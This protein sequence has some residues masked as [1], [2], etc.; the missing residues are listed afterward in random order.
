MQPDLSYLQG[1]MLQITWSDIK[2]LFSD[3]HGE[4]TEDT[5]H[6]ITCEKLVVRI[7][8]AQFLLTGA[9]TIDGRPLA[10]ATIAI[11]K[12]G[13]AITAKAQDWDVADGLVTVKNASLTLLIGKPGSADQVT[14]RSDEGPPA[15]RQKTEKTEPAP[16]TKTP[17][18]S[19]GLEVSGRVVIN[20]D[21]AASGR[22]PIDIGVTFVAG[23]QGKE[24]FWVLC[25]H[26]ESDISLSQFV[27]A[28]DEDSDIDF[29]LKSVSLIASNANDPACSVKTNGYKVRKGDAFISDQCSW[30]LKPT[31][32]VFY[33]RQIRTS[34]SRQS[35]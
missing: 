30:L 17:G 21:A 35:R 22:R 5:D 28:I 18:W 3:I 14:P 1:T 13:I 15:K 25:G 34:P 20:G 9:L 11:S 32:R 26:I 16:A 24:F 12:S 27:S 2:Q 33:L 19:G 6:I 10:E 29:R 8:Q 31:S 23:K 4:A 7:S